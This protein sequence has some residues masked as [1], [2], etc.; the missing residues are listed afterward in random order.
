[1]VQLGK[2]GLMINA[3]RASVFDGIRVDGSCAVGA[4]VEAG[5]GLADT[6]LEPKV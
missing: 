4:T 3:L 2:P 1:L 5:G 6:T